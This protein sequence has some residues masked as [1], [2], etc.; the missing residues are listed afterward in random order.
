MVGMYFAER[1]AN[2][3][4]YTYKRVVDIFVAIGSVEKGN[5]WEDRQ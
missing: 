1:K 2:V 5:V 4:L 3:I